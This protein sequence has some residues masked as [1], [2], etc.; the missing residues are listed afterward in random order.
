MRHGSV[1]RKCKLLASF[2]HCSH[3]L[4]VVNS[5]LMALLSLQLSKLIEIVTFYVR[6][7][8]GEVYIGHACLCV[9]MCVYVCLSLTAF[10][11]YCMDLDVTWGIGRGCPLV[12]H[13]WA[14]LYARVSLL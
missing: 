7:S 5:M 6:H 8:P 9:C 3:I 10:P 2:T 13:Y 12:V 4:P 11:R 14:D 1:V